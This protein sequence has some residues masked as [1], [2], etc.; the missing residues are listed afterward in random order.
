MK[1]YFKNK[2]EIE[3]Q[4]NQREESLL[5]DTYSREF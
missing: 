4:M 5:E 1:I 3:F 2:C